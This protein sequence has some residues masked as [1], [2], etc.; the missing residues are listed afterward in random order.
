MEAHYIIPSTLV[1][2]FKKSKQVAIWLFAC[3]THHQ[4]FY[5]EKTYVII[6]HQ[7]VKRSHL[8]N[9]SLKLGIVL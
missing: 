9:T 7:K 4:Y 1:Y 6:A 5:K 2:I 8:L 3:D